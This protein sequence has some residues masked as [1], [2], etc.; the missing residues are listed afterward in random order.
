MFQRMEI[1]NKLQL[2]ECRWTN[3]NEITRNAREIFPILLDG[4]SKKQ[5]PQSDSLRS[6][7][8]SPLHYTKCVGRIAIYIL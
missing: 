2:T 5:I 3:E 1:H 7:N 4:S 6:S 8:W